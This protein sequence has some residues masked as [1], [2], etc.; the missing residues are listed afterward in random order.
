MPNKRNPV[1]QLIADNICNLHGEEGQIKL[2]WLMA[3]SQ[4]P[5]RYAIGAGIVELLQRKGLLNET[6]AA[7]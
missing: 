2:I 7:L 3:E 1:A 4:E 6:A 5:V